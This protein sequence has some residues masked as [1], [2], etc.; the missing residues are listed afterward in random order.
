MHKGIVIRA[1]SSSSDFLGNTQFLQSVDDYR[2]VFASAAHH[3]FESVQPYLEIDSGLLSLK[4]DDATLRAIAAAARTEGIALPSLEIAPLQYSFTA[5]DPPERDRGR[6]V[7]ARALRVA[8]ALGCRGVLVIPGYV[9]L[10]WQAGCGAVVDYEAA[11][12][13][14]L[15]ALRALAADAESTGVHIMLENIWNMFLLSPRE[16]RELIDA[17]GRPEVGVLLDTGNVLQFGF[18][19]QWLRILGA[20]VLELH[21]KDFRRA[22]GTVEGFVPLLAGDVNWPAVMNALR[23]I[24]FDGHLI[25]ET[26]PYATHGPVA[27]A[28]VS[29]AID[30][31]MAGAPNVDGSGG[32][33]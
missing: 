8:G 14:T 19:E 26:F 3:G 30:A 4:T 5:D 1:F 21:L 22:V 24:N 6:A 2:R 17:V 29:R 15:E 28:H 23:E 11:Y 7:V 18:P 33:A 12:D 10:P 20:R 31:I 32:T 27:L 16:M 25:A 9:G 13:R